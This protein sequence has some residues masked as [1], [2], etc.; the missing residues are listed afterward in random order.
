MC[1]N[2]LV[3]DKWIPFIHS[4]V[5]SFVKH[6]ESTYSQQICSNI[7]RAVDRSDLFQVCSLAFLERADKYDSSRGAASTFLHRLFYNAMNDELQR[8]ISPLKVPAHSSVKNKPGFDRAEQYMLAIHPS[9]V[10]IEDLSDV[11]SG[12][13]GKNMESDVEFDDFSSFCLKKLEKGL[14]PEQLEVLIDR[15][16]GK[17]VSQIAEDFGICERQVQRMYKESLEK[18]KKILNLP[19][20]PVKS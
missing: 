13:D 4:V 5:R 17:T 12:T 19:S 16:G 10:P 3:L 14:D 20:A 8:S 7:F 2:K 11:L 1:G 6:V 18:A 15:F 9:G